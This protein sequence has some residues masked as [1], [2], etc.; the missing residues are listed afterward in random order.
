[1]ALVAIKFVLDMQTKKLRRKVDRARRI[2][3]KNSAKEVKREA[4]KSIRKARAHSAPGDPPKSKS[5]KFKKSIIYLVGRFNAWVG[6][7][8]PE[9][10]HANIIEGGSRFMEPRP[11]MGPA[12]ERARPKIRRFRKL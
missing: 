5:G 10:S 12:L 6:P 8:R 11:V 4:K 9:G 2:W 1:M 3:L 7:S